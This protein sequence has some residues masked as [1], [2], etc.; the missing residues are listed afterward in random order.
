M[1]PLTI[2]CS[3]FLWCGVPYVRQAE[4]PSLQ[5]ITRAKI[6][7]Q[8]TS[9][10]WSWNAISIL[11]VSTCWGTLKRLAQVFLLSQ[12]AAVSNGEWQQSLH[13]SCTA[14]QCWGLCCCLS[15]FL[16]HLQQGSNSL[17]V[18]K[19]LHLGLLCIS[20]VDWVFLSVKHS[21]EILQKKPTPC[22]YI[23]QNIYFHKIY[24][25]NDV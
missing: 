8:H 24:F 5:R 12:K 18:W 1:L 21:C 9:N 2:C 15:L 3:R 13:P 6:T 7:R 14:T 20:L 16:K 17:R 22:K 25:I 10:L 23:M 11:R 4:L 19:P